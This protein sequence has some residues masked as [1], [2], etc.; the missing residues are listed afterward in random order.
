[1][2]SGEK[3]ST[4]PPQERPRRGRRLRT[5]IPAP[6]RAAGLSR[7]QSCRCT[8]PAGGGSQAP[9]PV[10]PSVRVQGGSSL[11]RGAQPPQRA[12][13]GGG[14]GEPAHLCPS[15]GR[16]LRRHCRHQD[17][18]AGGPDLPV[19]PRERQVQG[20]APRPCAT[21]FPGDRGGS[22]ARPT[23]QSPR[24]VT[25]LWISKSIRER[26]ESK[27]LFLNE[28]SCVCNAE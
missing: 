16:G 27:L 17:R 6:G 25:L 14:V 23:P 18:R 13:G 12:G 26:A 22:R 5:S 24:N 7:Q 15:R 20:A 21:S 2:S 10:S 4:Q 19:T 1:M 3:E 28:H 11:V 9:G 8:E